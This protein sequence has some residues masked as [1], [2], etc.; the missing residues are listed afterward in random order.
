M[1]LE[2]RDS[3]GG[4][5]DT[6]ITADITSVS[7]TISIASATGWPSG[8]ANGP[9]FVIID[10]DVAGKEKVE[11]QSRTGTT[12]TIANTGKRGIDGTSAAGH[13][14]PAKIRHIHTRQDT[15]E[16]N[17]TMSQTVGK[18]TSKGDIIVATAANT[19][20]RLGVGANNQVP[21]ADSS[22]AT[23]WRWGTLTAA[24]LGTDSVGA[25][26]IATD[27][28]GAS[29][30][31]ADTVGTSE[32]AP[33]AVTSAELAANAVIAGKLANG[34]VDT[35][36]RFA[37]GVVDSAA[38]AANAVIAGKLANG[39]VDTAAR[40]VDGILTLV[41]FASEA[42]TLH[43][44]GAQG[45]ADIWAAGVNLGA[46]PTTYCHYY[47]LGRIVLGAA[48]FSMG[49]GG[50]VTATLQYSLPFVAADYFTG[51]GNSGGLVVG[52]VVS[53][54]SAFSGLGAILDVGTFRASDFI[55]A[56]STQAWGSTANNP[57]TWGTGS[58]F[59]S[60]F[61]YEATS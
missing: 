17:Y 40:V 44:S 31:G 47:K 10:Y 18:V 16:A 12:L 60:W 5:V 61:V 22:Q 1:A 28:V 34:S 4:A 41:K 8:G 46:G 36:A 56:G 58:I 19:F 26:Q 51:I 32:I 55:T 23:G 43:G 15:D 52:R 57:T 38:L 27:A 25:A 11:V 20:S 45:G 35:A 13:N 54:G 6:T 37:A 48:G 50:N 7:L 49:V 2:R 53:A 39:A 59:Q 14:A 29:E 3:A 42:S 33:L 21:I 30:I 9:F 24:S